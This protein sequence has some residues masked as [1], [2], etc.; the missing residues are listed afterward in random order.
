M[1]ERLV[2]PAL[3]S[4]EGEDFVVTFPDLPEALTGGTSIEEALMEAEDCLEEAIAARIDDGE[5]I[6]TPSEI[7]G[8]YAITCPPQMALKAALYELMT[9]AAMSKV[10]LAEMMEVNEKEVRRITDPHHNTKLQTLAKALRVL[11]KQIY[12][13][14]SDIPHSA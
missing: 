11:G 10:K 3:V 6:P 13:G 8:A 7:E 14:I 2:Y 1:K 4:G 9:E 12:I 5:E